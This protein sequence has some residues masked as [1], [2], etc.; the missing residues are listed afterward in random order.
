MST[1]RRVKG[2]YASKQPQGPNG[3][4]LCFNCLKP[5]GKG[6]K[7]NCSAK[8]SEEWRFKTSPSYVRALIVNR[9]HGICAECSADTIELRRAY[10]QIEI[11]GRK[12]FLAELGLAWSDRNRQTWWDADHIVPVAEG[13][14]ECDLSNY[15]TLCIMCHKKKTAAQAAKAKQERR[16][17][18]IKERDAAGLFAE[19]DGIEIT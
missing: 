13:G 18:K 11:D 15:Q 17:Q 14:G 1:E 16:E 2:V 12:A 9:D 5:V 8:C 19:V 10:L 6:R 7:F 4:P 3:E